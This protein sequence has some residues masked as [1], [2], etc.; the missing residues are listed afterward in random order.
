MSLVIATT[1]APASLRKC[2]HE[3]RLFPEYQCQTLR[4]DEADMLSGFAI[5]A[6]TLWPGYG[7]CRRLEK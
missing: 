3:V 1:N 6:S 5:G 2:G 7:E 4:N